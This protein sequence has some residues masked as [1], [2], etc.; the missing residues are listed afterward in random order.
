MPFGSISCVDSAVEFLWPQ[1]R[2]VWS[3]ATEKISR[4]QIYTELLFLFFSHASAPEVWFATN[5]GNVKLKTREGFHSSKALE[6]NSTLPT[7]KN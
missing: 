7:C 2:Q 3:S 4:Q 1:F 6:L 5:L